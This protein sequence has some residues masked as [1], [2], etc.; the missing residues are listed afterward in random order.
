MPNPIKPQEEAMLSYW[1]RGKLQAPPSPMDSPA[2]AAT[3]H[4]A[5]FANDLAI[6]HRIV[7]CKYFFPGGTAQLKGEPEN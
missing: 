7:R 2:S 6:K 1:Q 4:T 3:I 5:S